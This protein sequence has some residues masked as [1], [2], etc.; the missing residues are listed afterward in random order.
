MVGVALPAVAATPL[1]PKEIK[2][3]FATGK[4]FNGVTVPGKM[5]YTLTLNADGSSLLTLLKGDKTST[6]GTWRVSDT[7]YCSKWAKSTEHCYT[8]QKA[9]KEYDVLNASTKVIAHWTK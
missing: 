7:G 1:T 4:P 8:V 2:T 9:G 5:T 6:K 3:V